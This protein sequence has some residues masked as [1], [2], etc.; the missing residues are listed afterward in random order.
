MSIFQIV[1]MDP[2]AAKWIGFAKQ[3]CKRIMDNGTKDF[4][5]EWTLEGSTIKAKSY[6]G[7]VKLWLISTGNDLI[8]GQYFGAA[9]PPD[10]KYYV[11]TDNIKYDNTIP[12]LTLKKKGYSSITTNGFMAGW[13]GLPNQRESSWLILSTAFSVDSTTGHKL[14]SVTYVAL[15][16][17]GKTKTVVYDID[18]LLP[19]ATTVYFG[20]SAPLG[21]DTISVFQLYDSAL[22]VYKFFACSRTDRT[23]CEV[24]YTTTFAAAATQNAVWV[25]DGTTFQRI[26][27]VD[28]VL[29][30][31]KVVI[32]S[33]VGGV[34]APFVS[35]G[36][37]SIGGANQ[38]AYNNYIQMWMVDEDLTVT[39]KAYT[40]ADIAALTGV[41][42]GYGAQILSVV[43]TDADVVS[44]SYWQQNTWPSPCVGIRATLTGLSILS[45]L[46]T[47]APSMGYPGGD[48]IDGGNLGDGFFGVCYDDAAGG[49]LA[50]YAYTIKAFDAVGVLQDTTEVVNTNQVPSTVGVVGT[51]AKA[52]YV[53]DTGDYQR[54]YK[55]RK[56]NRTTK[57]WSLIAPPTG[58]WATYSPL[59]YATPDVDFIFQRAVSPI[60]TVIFNAADPAFT[61]TL[62]GLYD[63][64]TSVY[65]DAKTRTL[66]V[67]NQIAI[68]NVGRKDMAFAQPTAFVFKPPTT[69]DASASF[70]SAYQRP[71]SN[72]QAAVF[73]YTQAES[74]GQLWD[75]QMAAMQPALPP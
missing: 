5:R 52:V 8:I 69:S 28:G 55:L 63:G 62:T 61:V 67:A 27:K 25:V 7:T 57:K 2:D 54:I 21:A 75:T 3:Q 29:T 37:T 68:I 31:T 35:V 72:T 38:D 19:G 66:I 10:G 53:W 15:K 70:I 40:Q 59:V 4:Y 65:Y 45:P 48:M 9:V 34:N 50:S 11:A 32:P 41:G 1:Q 51:S 46:A 16:A 36:L 56:F 42:G 47:S 22:G 20:T 24:S 18:S 73:A 30:N 6:G 43:C 39:T 26:T 64:P 33:S 17:T 74:W 12:T 60:R 14:L 58:V 44:C 23:F 71:A 49:Y 13:T